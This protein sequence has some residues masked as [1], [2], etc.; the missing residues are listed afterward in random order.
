MNPCQAARGHLAASFSSRSARHAGATLLA[1][2]VVLLSACGGNENSGGY[3][4]VTL[5][6]VSS[7]TPVKYQETGTYVITG[8]GLNLAGSVTSEDCSNVTVISRS[9][10]AITFSCTATSTLPVFTIG[11]QS[12]SG[13]AYAVTP[14]SVTY[15]V[16]STF[17][18][19]GGDLQSVAPPTSSDCAGIDVTE[20]TDTTMIFTCTPHPTDTPM[21]TSFR[22]TTATGAAVTLKNSRVSYNVTGAG[23][24]Y[25]NTS[26]FAIEGTGLADAAAPTSTD[27]E[28]ISVLERSNTALRFTC[29]PW[30]DTSAM[31]T[32][33]KVT[34]T[35]VAE[36]T[37]SYTVP[38]PRVTI[39]T[40]MGTMVV[41]MYPAYAPITV[42]N[43]LWYVNSG[44]YAGTIFHRVT[45]V[46]DTNSYAIIQG[47][48]FTGANEAGTDLIA[49]TGTTQAP[50]TLET[51]V[52][53]NNVVLSNIAG[54]VAMARTAEPNS[55]QAQFFVNVSDNRSLFNYIDADHPGYA[56]FGRV[57]SGIEIVN[58]I[59]G[60]DVH[61]VGS[62]ANVPVTD[63]VITSATQTQ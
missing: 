33:F 29:T 32:S 45:T 5:T 19:Y 58:S 62:Y 50:I 56:V 43:Y 21:S 8:S 55:A 53:L 54:A 24:K 44:Y 52:G 18:L 22:L 10:S 26:T 13:I 57:V 35:S 30:P 17:K 15:G 28:E 14:I 11:S 1:L 20:Q 12:I 59:N 2:S 49:S 36:Q 34:P 23:V 3:N 40:S 60:V 51:N 47:G 42:K 38:L 41:E 39:E 25:A 46:T 7:P 63:V 27:C 16:S 37:V 9:D 6:S 61:T 48:G 31:T 4:K